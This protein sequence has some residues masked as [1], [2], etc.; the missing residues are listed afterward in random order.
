LSEQEQ[1]LAYAAYLR[2]LQNP[3]YYRRLYLEGDLTNPDLAHLHLWVQYAED[4]AFLD[5]F[6]GIDL[7]DEAYRQLEDIAGQLAAGEIS[8]EEA[9]ALKMPYLLMLGVGH[10][11]EIGSGDVGGTHSTYVVKEDGE[12]IYVGRTKRPLKKRQQEHRR[13]PGRENWNLEVDRTGLT[14]EQAHGRE[15]V[16]FDTYSPSENQKRPLSL[17]ST[18]D[19]GMG[20]TEPSPEPGAI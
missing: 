18:D 2:Y 17:F 6:L 20:N 1:A 5:M 13:I 14:K 3:E 11:D 19:L 8:D 7:N 16:L 9:T 12:V 4:P 15:Q 10:I